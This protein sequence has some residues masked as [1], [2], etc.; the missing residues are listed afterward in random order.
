MIVAAAG[1]A[2]YVP[3]SITRIPERR[4]VGSLKAERSY[5]DTGHRPE[6]RGHSVESPQPKVSRRFSQRGELQTK[7]KLDLVV[8]LR[9]L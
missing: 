7:T 8:F 9:S 6:A 2:M 1:P 5:Y 4:F 3:Q